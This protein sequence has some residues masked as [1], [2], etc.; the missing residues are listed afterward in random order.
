LGRALLAMACRDAAERG[1]SLV[2]LVAHPSAEA[3][4]LRHGAIRIGELKG[5]MLGTPRD[6]QGHNPG[7]IRSGKLMASLSHSE[8]RRRFPCADA[9][10]SW[11][12]VPHSVVLVGASRR[13]P[14]RG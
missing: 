4:H 1:Y 9:Q 2:E 14:P 6:V 3:F 5:S 10:T 7:R 8:G 12:G 13:P 11:L